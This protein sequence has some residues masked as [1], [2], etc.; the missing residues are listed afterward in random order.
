[1]AF[2][3]RFRLYLFGFGLG[4]LFVYGV[5]GDRDVTSWLPE[6]KILTAI[7]SSQ[8]SI[9]KRALCQLNCNGFSE[10]DIPSLMDAADIDFGESETQREPCPIYNITTQEGKYFMKWE[11]CEADEKVKLLLFEA[12]G[13]CAC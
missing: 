13:K 11:V 10:N 3:K 7:D 4:L 2:W 12:G 9:T 1:M 6:R 8:V 5:F